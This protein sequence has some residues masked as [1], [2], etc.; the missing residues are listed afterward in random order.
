M[1][2][3]DVVNVFVPLDSVRDLSVPPL[4]ITDGSPDPSWVEVP[5][6]SRW[7]YGRRRVIRLPFDAVTAGV[8]GQRIR[9]ERRRRVLWTP[10]AVALTVA[11]LV[12]VL[13]VKGDWADWAGLAIYGVSLV[14]QLSVAHRDRKLTV[15]QWPQLI[16]RL[17][18]FLPAVSATVAGE[19]AQRNAAVR[20]VPE[21]PRWRRYPSLVYRWASG[22]CVVAGIGVWWFALRDGEFYTTTPLV[23]VV[24]L[25]AAVVLAFKAL[26]PGFVRFDDVQNH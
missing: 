22:A 25:G 20:I 2:A 12:L 19:W 11:A 14:V 15:A 5:C 26:P 10:G 18:V 6:T 9:F 16:G 13:A 3:D 24:L 7:V 21:R 8:A 23:F 4:A 17:G 1:S